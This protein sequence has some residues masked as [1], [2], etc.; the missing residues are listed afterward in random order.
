MKNILESD[1]SPKC[2]LNYKTSRRKKD[3]MFFALAKAKIFL[4]GTW[5]KKA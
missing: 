5:T 4:D 2:K 1:H 3:K